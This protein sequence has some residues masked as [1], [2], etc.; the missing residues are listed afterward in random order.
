M[1]NL[2]D[3]IARGNAAPSVQVASWLDAE[4]QFNAEHPDDQDPAVLEFEEAQKAIEQYQ[5][6]VVR[7]TEGMDQDEL[8]AWCKEMDAWRAL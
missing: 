7:E 4:A 2:D 6:D 3:L 1:V 5:R 8:N